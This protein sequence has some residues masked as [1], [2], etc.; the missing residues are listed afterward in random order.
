M[1]QVPNASAAE[2]TM[3]DSVRRKYI[4]SV[5]AN[6]KPPQHRSPEPPE[7]QPTTTP[8]S[9]PEDDMT[10]CFDMDDSAAD[11]PAPRD[12]AAT[13]AAESQTPRAITAAP[14]NIVAEERKGTASFG[15]VPP[16][17]VAEQHDY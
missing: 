16:H 1:A 17:L 4:Q 9:A 5:L 8:P 3:V 6:H 2:I 11:S 10:F 15:F 14:E 12:A 13:D 7:P